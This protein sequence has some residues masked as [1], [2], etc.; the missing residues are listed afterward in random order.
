MTL[1]ACAVSREN[2]SSLNH[3]QPGDPRENNS[4]CGE[5]CGEKRTAHL[6]QACDARLASRPDSRADR[7][8]ARLC[9]GTVEVLVAAKVA[10]QL[11]TFHPLV[12]A[13]DTQWPSRS[14]LTLAQT[15]Q[16]STIPEAYAQWNGRPSGLCQQFTMPL[17]HRHAG[18]SERFRIDF[19]HIGNQPAR[20]PTSWRA[21]SRP[22]LRVKTLFRQTGNE[23]IGRWC[24]SLRVTPEYGSGPRRAAK[25]RDHTP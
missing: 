13:Q 3:G 10:R 4:P 24:S 15:G 11:T 20:R 25:R 16:C 8:Q 21:W 12:I 22:G 6:E 17:P 5:K 18:K 14:W 19:G 2:M 1:A 7:P 23:I 9:P